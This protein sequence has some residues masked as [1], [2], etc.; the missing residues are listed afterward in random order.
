MNDCVF[1][2]KSESLRMKYRY[3]DLRSSEMQ[4]NLRLRSQLVMRMREFLCNQH[5]EQSQD[6]PPL[7][8]TRAGRV[9]LEVISYLLK[10]VIGNLI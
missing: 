6:Q 4:R 5:G 9:T 10:K 2:Q 8:G 3:L 7:T 1:A